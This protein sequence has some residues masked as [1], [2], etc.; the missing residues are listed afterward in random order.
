MGQQGDVRLTKITTP[1]PTPSGIPY[2]PS[3]FRCFAEA[4]D[5][6]ATGATG[7]NFFS[8]RGELVETLPYTLLREQALD[9]A[10]K[11]L[12]TGLV[13]GDRVAILAHSDGDFVRAF[14]GCQYAGLIPVP[15]PLPTAMG[16]RSGYITKTR[17]MIEAAKA[18][19]AV[20][21]ATLEDW[22]AEATEGLPLK[23]SG[24][25][26]KLPPLQN[27]VPLPAITGD[28]TAYLQFSSGSTRFPMGITITHKAFV[29]NT[30][31]IAK[32]GL[33]INANDRCVSW[34][35][36]YH[37]LG[38]VGFLLVPIMTQR[39]VDIIPT[40]EFARRPLN[41]LA[42][43]STYGGTLS[44]GP[45]FA[46]DLC[47]RRVGRSKALETLDLSAWRAAGIG[48]DMVRPA[49]LSKFAETF[50]ACGFKATALTPSYGMAEITLAVSFPPLGT[51][52]IID[53]LDLTQ[54][55]QT[56]DVVAANNDTARIRSFARCGRALPGHVVEVRDADG[57]PLPD[58]RVGRL[59]VRGPSIMTEYFDH[60]AESAAALTPDGWLNTG[61]LGYLCEGDIVI[62][63][64]AK[65]L[66]I[67]NGRNIWPQD[68]EW[69][70][71]RD[72]GALRT[73]D[74]C[75]FS[76]DQDSNESVTI[77][78]QSRATTPEARQEL[79]ADVAEVL[80]GAHGI[81]CK[82]VLIPNNSL[83]FTTSGKLSRNQSRLMYLSGE[84]AEVEDPA[85]KQPE[86][87]EQ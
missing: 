58:K 37:D 28:G 23:F 11:L 43:I 85:K 87:A 1:T 60:P 13:P 84:L 35:P 76:V 3:E 61:D 83:P 50:A 47:T 40:Q 67:I 62:T 5:Y 44:F 33:E 66:I 54:L 36:F 22:L 18:S 68:I 17:R 32:Y 21:P 57:T 38:L 30:S 81:V 41:W 55:E 15:L 51:G 79:R 6:A 72:L 45:T 65:D 70:L 63:G 48:G 73:G 82:I 74:V 9:V 71:E 77:L 49:V 56:G 4:L 59:F 8:G 86:Q 46:Y 20:G 69:S 10:Q 2:K 34:L 78:V 80:S 42:I 16:G 24:L 25:L 39:T 53:K 27:E 31:A 64:R 52:L 19:A 75:A 7:V 12:A 26:S 14:A 29:A